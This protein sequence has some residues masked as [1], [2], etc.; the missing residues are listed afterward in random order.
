MNLS[1][2]LGCGL[3]FSL[4]R[5]GKLVA[6]AG[7]LRS[8]PLGNGIAVR[9]PRDLIST[10]ESVFQKRD[11]EFEFIAQPLEIKIEGLREQYGKS[12]SRRS[13]N[14]LTDTFI[15]FGGIATIGDYRV[16]VRHGPYMIVGGGSESVSIC[17]KQAFTHAAS[18]FAARL[19]D[20]PASSD[21]VLVATYFRLSAS[22]N[23]V[24]GREV[25]RHF[26]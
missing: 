26:K 1:R 3:G 5:R 4:G 16:I 10:A 18:E 17:D 13:P 11:P 19:L 9:T 6:A 2:D 22:N 21:N 7:A 23:G 24:A 25:R 14:P 15:A 20:D 8:V 12:P